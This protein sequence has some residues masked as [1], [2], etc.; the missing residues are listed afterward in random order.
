MP[1]FSVVWTLAFANFMVQLNT[2]YRYDNNSFIWDA[3][4]TAIHYIL[5]FSVMHAYNFWLHSI[6]VLKGEQQLKDLA[7]QSEIKALKSQIE[8]HFLFNTLNSISASV[9]PEM[10]KTRVMIAQLADTF[11]HALR[12]SEKTFVTLEEEME[13][14]RNWLSL[15]KHRFDN[16]L[17][18]HF[19]LEDQIMQT[20]IPPMILQP[21]VENA[22]NHGISP[23]VDGGS[24][25]I[26]CKKKDEFVSIW[27]SDTGIGYK[28]DLKTM[29]TEG[30]GLSNVYK[31]LQLVYNQSLVVERNPEGLRLS[32]KIPLAKAYEKE[33]IH[34]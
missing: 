11:R 32:F 2:N 26:G 25:T 34:Y 24:V 5:T 23:K 10:E 30:I 21:L 33:S 16:R 15:E 7:Y 12:S 13:F 8:P 3:H 9:P 14:L 27:V 29:L 6:K 17:V 18:V 1:L 19:D 28:A 22:L 20:Q 4:A 31:R